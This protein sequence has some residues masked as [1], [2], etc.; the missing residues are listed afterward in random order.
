M[1]NQTNICL[2]PKIAQPELV[3]QFPLISLCNTI[4]KVVSKVIVER[5]MDC[6]P[7]IVSPIKMRFMPGRIIHE[8]I[9]VVQEMIHNMNKIKLKGSW[10]GSR[11]FIWRILTKIKLRDKLVDVIMH[12]VTSVDNISPYLISK[13]FD[14]GKYIILS[15]EMVL[16]LIFSVLREVSVKGSHFSLFICYVYG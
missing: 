13:T 15:N 6:I 8:N 4:Y 3:N 11:E 1:V 12:F 7:I 16:E 5:L 10:V 2:I 9:V 14:K